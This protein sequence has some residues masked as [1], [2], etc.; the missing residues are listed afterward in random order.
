MTT[1]SLFF[2]FQGS[3]SQMQ[4]QSQLAIG[5]TPN[6][7]SAFIPHPQALFPRTQ[8]TS[9]LH[10]RNRGACLHCAFSS[11]PFDQSE[12]SGEGKQRLQF[13]LLTCTS[14]NKGGTFRVISGEL[15]VVLNCFRS[16]KKEHL[17]STRV[18]GRPTTIL[19]RAFC[20]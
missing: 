8:I 13:N 14:F 12:Y 18:R 6:P 1:I 11:S 16:I 2:V 20:P 3:W 4:Q 5:F 19:C 10:L 15:T 9:Q 17:K 7:I